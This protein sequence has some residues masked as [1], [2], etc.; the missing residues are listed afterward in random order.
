MTTR[1]AFIGTG[2]IVF[3]LLALIPG[4]PVSALVAVLVVV[5]IPAALMI[6]MGGALAQ[7]AHKTRQ[8]RG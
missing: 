2:F 3:A 5:G 1:N 4:V 7:D 8:H 6:T